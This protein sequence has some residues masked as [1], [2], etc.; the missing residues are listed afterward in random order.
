VNRTVSALLVA[1][2]C[3]AAVGVT[4][5]AAHATAPETAPATAESTWMVC[6]DG[7]PVRDGSLTAVTVVSSTSMEGRFDITGTITP[8]HPSG[9]DGPKFAVAFYGALGALVPEGGSQTYA[10]L[11][12]GNTFTLHVTV[13][14]NARALCLV[15]N[16]K[17]RLDCVGLGWPLGAPATVTGHISTYA[18]QVSMPL[19]RAGQI[20]PGPGCPTCTE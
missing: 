2:G 1:A 6:P 16:E 15:S 19:G 12:P 7:G 10:S 18:P 4:A 5:F 3:A 8:C 17:T 13:P 11:G 9:A 20:A 14:G